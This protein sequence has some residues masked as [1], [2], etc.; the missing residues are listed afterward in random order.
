[1]YQDKQ[2]DIIN[3]GRIVTRIRA[4]YMCSRDRGERA[5]EEMDLKRKQI[6]CRTRVDSSSPSVNKTSSDIHVHTENNV[7]GDFQKIFLCCYLFVQIYVYNNQVEGGKQTACT[8]YNSRR[9][10]AS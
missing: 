10:I 4:Q 5:I 7:G 8:L 9:S 1:M 3:R 2:V 6:I